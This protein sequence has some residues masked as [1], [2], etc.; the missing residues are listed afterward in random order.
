MVTNTQTNGTNSVRSPTAQNS[1]AS[2]PTSTTS[3]SPTRTTGP[4]QQFCSFFAARTPMLSHKEQ[5]DQIQ[6]NKQQRTNE[7][8][9]TIDWRLA[10]PYHHASPPRILQANA[11]ACRCSDRRCYHRDGCQWWCVCLWR[12]R[13]QQN[14]HADSEQRDEAIGAPFC[15]CSTAPEGPADSRERRCGGNHQCLY[16]RQRTANDHIVATKS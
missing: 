9:S 6:T 16:H 3:T 11:A 7:R 8:P 13:Q 12:E 4:Q 5:H 2:A 14:I 10:T 15:R 1:A